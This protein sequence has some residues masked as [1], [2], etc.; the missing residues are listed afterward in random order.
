MGSLAEI[1]MPMK[2]PTL[3][4]NLLGALPALAATLLL[5]TLSSSAQESKSP[6]KP[7]SAEDQLKL[8]R[9]GV[10]HEKLAAYVGAWTVEVTIG[11]GLRALKYQGTSQNRMTVG[12]RFLQMEYQAKGKTN[13]TEGLFTVGFDPRHQRH[14]L[15]AM[16]DFGTYFVTSQGQRDSNTGKIRMLGTD[17]DPVM[18]A[19]GLT[20]EFVHVLDLRNPDEF[21]VEVWFIDTRNAARKEFKYMDYIFKRKK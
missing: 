3:L 8:A 11:S 14:T 17:D 2:K 9:P 20:K 5:A 16:D 10:E 6:S 4:T 7:P 21:A 12:G 13:S 18:K 1:S 19:M 15:I